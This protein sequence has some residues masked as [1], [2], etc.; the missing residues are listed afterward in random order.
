MNHTSFF[1]FT[2]VNKNIYKTTHCESSVKNFELSVSQWKK[3]SRYECWKRFRFPLKW[4]RRS[5]LL[6][7]CLRYTSLLYPSTPPSP[8]PPHPF[9]HLVSSFI[10]ERDDGK[11]RTNPTRYGLA[12]SPWN[13]LKIL[14][15][16]LLYNKRLNYLLRF[17]WVSPIHYI[18]SSMLV[19]RRLDHKFQS[20][21]IKGL[22]KRTGE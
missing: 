5:R 18:C 10:R 22:D 9:C 6:S 1:Y 7:Q 17:L 14:L 8:P 19:I 15:R 21:K 13:K 16:H 20:R 4:R 12:H 3:E 2:L 11:V